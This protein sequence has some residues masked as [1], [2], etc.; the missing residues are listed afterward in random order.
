[1]LDTKQLFNHISE[2][3]PITQP[4]FV[5][6]FNEGLK[7]VSSMHNDDYI[8]DDDSTEITELVVYD[9]DTGIHEIYFDAFLNYIMFKHKKE[10]FFYNLFQK[11]VERAFLKRWRTVNADI[12]IERRY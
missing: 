2:E 9:G 1:M 8:L 11:A 7:I 3:T 4:E 5:R 12:T 10:E 6:L